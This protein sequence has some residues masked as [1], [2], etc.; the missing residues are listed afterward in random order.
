MQLYKSIALEQLAKCYT[1]VF[2]ANT[3]ARSGRRQK[4]THFGR[5]RWGGVCGLYQICSMD[6]EESTLIP[7]QWRLVELI[8]QKY[9]IW[10]WANEGGTRA[11]AVVGWSL[12]RLH[13]TG[14]VLCMMDQLN[15]HQCPVYHFVRPR[16][17]RHV[18]SFEGHLVNQWPHSKVF[19]P[20]KDF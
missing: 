2:G 13:K 4:F 18:T 1:L 17:E 11:R 12:I 6:V 8:K 5:I 15:C 14:H 16:G 3:I 19:F 9:L 20:S 7:I 10:Q